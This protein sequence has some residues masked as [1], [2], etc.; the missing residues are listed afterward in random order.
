MLEVLGDKILVK[1]IE[2]EEEEKQSLIILPETQKERS[3]LAEVVTVGDGILLSSGVREPLKVK[4]GDQ[5]IF[6]MFA[7]TPVQYDG[8]TYLIIRQSEIL[9][10]IK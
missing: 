3:Q 8:V 6:E 9:A 4:A 7:G 2:K 5:V 1:I 10:I